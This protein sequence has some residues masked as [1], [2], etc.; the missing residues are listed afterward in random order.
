MVKNSFLVNTIHIT[1][2][3]HED[4][5][6]PFVI[7]QQEYP[8]NSISFSSVI[9]C[10]IYIWIQNYANMLTMQDQQSATLVKYIETIGINTSC[11]KMKSEKYW[12][13]LCILFA[14]SK[15]LC[16]QPTVVTKRVVILVSCLLGQD[17]HGKNKAQGFVVL[18][19][20]KWR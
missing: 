13:F 7:F 18:F 14:S 17:R 12:C 15:H 1:N 2:L 3:K 11:V 16:H 10:T 6:L 5:H 20:Y 9:S 8:N 4:K 19:D